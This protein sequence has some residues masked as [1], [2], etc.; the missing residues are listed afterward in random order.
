VS[1]RAV[2]ALGMLL[3]LTATV[4]ADESPTEAEAVPDLS[5]F[6]GARWSMSYPERDYEG[7]C[8]V[9]FLSFQFYPNGFFTYNVK[10][11]G[12]WRLDDEGRL[13]LRTRD[14]VRFTLLQEG[15]GLHATRDLPF[16]RR[17]NVFRRCPE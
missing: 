15:D 10:V 13:Q 3:A 14:G 1:V 11:R 16:L 9:G 5:R 17:S 8:V 12:V 4:R 6:T 2:A 7:G